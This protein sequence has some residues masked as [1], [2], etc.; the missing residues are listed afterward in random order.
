[1]TEYFMNRLNVSG[2]TIDLGGRHVSYA[3]E[4]KFFVNAPK[5][6]N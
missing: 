6:N 5:S 3:V 2:D 4:T 1:M